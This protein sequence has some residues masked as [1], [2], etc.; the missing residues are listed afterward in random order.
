MYFFMQKS[1]DMNKHS[2]QGQC[3]W[4]LGAS[5]GIGAALA[6]DLADKG[7]RIA[8]SARNSEDLARLKDEL[9]GDGHLALPLDVTDHGAL[10]HA[11]E[12]I[13]QS[14]G[15]LDSAVF[16]AALYREH[17]GKNA[18]ID[19]I[20]KMM[21]VNVGGAFNMVDVVQPLFEAQ[22]HG[23]IAL[24]ASVAGYRGLPHGQ[25]YCANKAALINLAESL[26]IDLSPKNIDVKV[27]NP[28]FV[29]TRL[30]DKN[31]FKMPMIIQVDE[32]G[33]AVADGLISK[34][35]EIHFPKKFTFIMKLI[36]ALPA[37]LYFMVAKRMK[38]KL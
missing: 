28:G 1:K 27:I 26:K 7:A 37:P 18:D 36:R 32:A 2:H 34:S 35:F 22:G 3:Y 25:P 12:E 30:T 31:K 29:K 33:K 14:F 4:I 11:L 6:R 20:H 9:T 19:F 17:D 8:L 13:T 23:Q 5:S 15:K 24:C 16:M 10:V 38:S 21:N